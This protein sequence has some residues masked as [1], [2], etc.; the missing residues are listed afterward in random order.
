LN[1]LTN[2]G[3]FSSAA[4]SAMGNPW[5]LAAGGWGAPELKYPMA[6]LGAHSDDAIGATTVW[7]NF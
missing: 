5:N 6:H 4:G 1:S 3:Q 2:P 7:R